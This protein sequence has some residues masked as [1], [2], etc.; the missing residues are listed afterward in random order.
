MFELIFWL[1]T[2]VI[3]YTYFG[4]PL[5]S[6]F[7]SLFIDHEID[8]ADIEPAVTFLITAYNEGKNIRQKL[9]D[10]LGLDY[11]GDKLEIMVASDGSS[12]KTDEIV[13]Q[14]AHRGVV[15]HRVEGRVGKTETQNRAVRVARGDII[16]FSDATT[17]YNRDAIR[18]I[19]RNYND[20]SIG[21]V[22]GKYE[23]VNPTGAPVGLGTVL[24]WK[25]E[26][27]I[28][29]RQARIKTIT[30]C[31]GCIY[32]VRRSLYEPLPKDII[33]DLVEPLK[34]LEKGYRIAFEPEAVAYETTEEKP[35]EEFS[36]RVRVI[37]RGMNGLAYVRSLLNPF[38]YP[39]VAFQ[40]ISHKIIRWLMPFFLIILFVSNVL[41]LGIPAYR[42]I[43]LLQVVFYV[44]V[45]LAWAMHKYGKKVKFLFLP[46]YF[47]IVN[48]ASVLAILNIIKGTKMPTWQTVRK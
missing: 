32:S 26:N 23:Y 44:S 36:M 18:K 5:L 42:L 43:F 39:F 6:L 25:Y 48:L 29:K 4:Y 13:K 47:C 27:F 3:F 16:I 34:I 40:L 10:T 19:V 41:L 35:D 24:F 28:K 22:S 45:P 33:S 20:P 46:L 11:P 2:G 17:H 37:T 30:G 1:T 8:K 15:L 14:F 21:A 38:K 31:C 12:D 9:E 7:L